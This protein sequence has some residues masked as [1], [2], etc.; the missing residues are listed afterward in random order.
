MFTYPILGGNKLR[1]IKGKIFL[2]T[3]LSIIGIIILILFNFLSSN[4]VNQARDEK[5]TLSN[6]V[7][8]SKDIKYEMANT[9]QYERQYLRN[10]SEETVALVTQSMTLVQTDS[11][12][13]KIQYEEYPEISK[14]FEKINQS[15][16]AYITNYKEL[17]NLY[18]INGYSEKEGLLARIHEAG[19]NLEKA[20]ANHNTI[21]EAL[22]NIRLYEKQYISL[23]DSKV[24]DSFTLHL[25]ELANRNDVSKPFKEQLTNYASIMGT[26]ASH[27]QAADNIITQLDAIGRTVEDA[28][29]QLDTLVTQEQAAI[30]STVNKQEAN[31]AYISY[32]ISAFTILTLLIVGYFLARSILNSISKL[33]SGAK[34][35]G[36][37]DLTYEVDVKQK[38]EMYQLADTFNQM[39]QKV[40]LSLVEVR[41]SAEKLSAS[42]QHLSAISEETTAQSIE[43]NTAIQQMATGASRQAIDLEDANLILK[44]VTDSIESTRQASIEI[45]HEAQQTKEQGNKGLQ[46]IEVLTNTSEE[47]LTLSNL[48][49]NQIQEATDKAEAISGI[50][51][52]IEEIAENT[53]LL[54]LNAAIEAARAGE[55]G[56]GFSIVA[57]EVRKLAERSKEE[58]QMIQALILSMNEQ[59]QQLAA[60][61]KRLEEFKNVQNNSVHYTTTAFEKIV[62]SVAG[63]NTKILNIQSAIKEIMDSNNE[64]VSKLNGIHE[65]SEQNAASA[66]EINAS[67]D[68][69]LIAINQVNDAAAQLSYIAANLQEVVLQF[70]LEKN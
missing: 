6:A 7:V 14:Q 70:K 8:H 21:R 69:Q 34:T 40:K 63:I 46:T 26:I 62:S 64:L 5:D 59:M 27:Y 53:D 51:K 3:C 42:S 52:T 1:T 57:Q 47:F 36:T 12:K 43:V 29:K 2:C 30:T 10:P 67:S 61:S 28:S 65:I 41:T 50:V 11:A 24:Y 31:I 48:L 23:K 18:S 17:V 45:V 39:A 4:I 35:I 13:L 37:G 54:A 44:N 38:D 68:G 22:F 49:T 16:S 32:G 60:H 19:D 66:Q 56:K 33:T 20:S 55:A 25:Q 15:A 9:R 58:S